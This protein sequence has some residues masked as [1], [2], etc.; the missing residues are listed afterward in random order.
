M[1][2]RGIMAQ[3]MPMTQDHG[4][5]ILNLCVSDLNKQLLLSCE[6]L[7]PVLLDNLLLDPEHPRMDDRS[8]L[9]TKTDW[10]GTKGPV[11]RVS[12]VC[13]FCSQL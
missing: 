4:K 9:G 7:I 2:H 3:L 13:V 5:A 11:Q 1:D 12:L 8:M 10:E 6:E